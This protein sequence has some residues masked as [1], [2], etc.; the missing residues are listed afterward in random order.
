MGVVHRDM[1]PENI[2]LDA[3]WRIRIT[4]FGSAKCTDRDAQ[5]QALSAA[6]TGED[7]LRADATDA[8]ATP[9]PSLATSFVGTA[10]FVSP[11]LLDQK[12]TTFMSD[13]WAFG[14]ILYT[15]IA[16]VPPF[17]GPSE[18]TTFQK[19]LHDPVTFPPAFPP[20]AR[21]FISAFLQRNPAER[22]SEVRWSAL[23]NHPFFRADGTDQVEAEAGKGAVN[24]VFLDETA[25]SSG[26]VT[27]TLENDEAS[28]PKIWRDLWTK[29]AP[30]L[31]A[32]IVVRPETPEGEA[33]D[34]FAMFDTESELAPTE[35][36][37]YSA[38]LHSHSIASVDPHR[39]TE[40][41]GG[42]ARPGLWGSPPVP[43]RSTSSVSGV[44]VNNEAGEV[45][46]AD[47]ELDDRSSLAPSGYESSLHRRT[48]SGPVAGRPRA[49]GPDW[50][51]SPV[52]RHNSLRPINS[53][54]SS[55]PTSMK[56]V[57][58][59]SV[60]SFD[61]A[62]PSKV[63][64]RLKSSKLR[65]KAKRRLSKALFAAQG[66]LA[67]HVSHH[68]LHGHTPSSPA[69]RSTGYTTSAPASPSL[70]QPQSTG[71]APSALPP[72]APPVGVVQT[73]PGPATVINSS[74]AS[75]AGG[76][77]SPTASPTDAGRAVC[78]RLTPSMERPP[79]AP[80][81]VSTGSTGSV[82]DKAK[83]NSS[84]S[85]LFFRRPSVRTSSFGPGQAST[86]PTPPTESRDDPGLDLHP[87]QDPHPHT[88]QPST[89]GGSVDQAWRMRPGENIVLVAPVLQRKSGAAYL[90]SPKRRDLVL[91][92]LGRLV[93]V[94]PPL[95]QGNL[96]IEFVLAPWARPG[97]AVLP[98]HSP[99]PLRDGD[100]DVSFVAA[101]AAPV[102]ELVI[103]IE[104]RGSKAFVLTT[105]SKRQFFYED[106][107]GDNSYWLRA[108][109]RVMASAPVVPARAPAS[110]ITQVQTQ[111]NSS[112]MSSSLQLTSPDFIPASPKATTSVTAPTT[113][114]AEC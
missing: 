48:S 50:P 59:A 41:P 54:A 25:A 57:Q 68:V 99:S 30:P 18:Y 110:P 105:A 34:V 106:P 103:S 38:S 32:G 88:V 61:R 28:L 23:A 97:G 42:S 21:S 67:H 19:I 63:R 112:P 66:D 27:A 44:P 51:T 26:D 9:H 74:A 82:G 16:G 7:A 84:P 85:R 69:L 96:K 24:S 47:N 1:K 29:P 52:L 79:L 104:P 11:E 5:G 4:D 13:W 15:L 3:E 113:P 109:R 70:F 35:D 22:L 94:K 98:L 72:R 87:G 8:D 45:N 90:F 81:Y 89:S 55:P 31:K 36:E 12:Q 95:G 58:R 65:H 86:P 102:P 64:D 17:R 37:R 107:S 83:A 111:S 76:T 93:V 6:A 43:G 40:G 100:Q 49:Y 20:A 39:T 80:V 53:S 101:A 92:D 56:N 33:E 77:N 75:Y 10:E 62:S 46:D 60:G 108:L 2:L 73:P 78:H 114:T 14:A 91:T 71:R